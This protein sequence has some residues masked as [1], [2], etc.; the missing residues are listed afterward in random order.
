MIG[1]ITQ[2]VESGGEKGVQARPMPC[3]AE[4]IPAL[5]TAAGRAMIIRSPL[6]SILFALVYM[7]CCRICLQRT[8]VTPTKKGGKTWRE[9]HLSSEKTF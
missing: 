4:G 3:T 2:F 5:Q 7:R 8:N 6:R 1:I 9:D